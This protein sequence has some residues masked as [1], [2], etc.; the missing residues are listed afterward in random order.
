MTAEIISWLI[1]TKVWDRA[2]IELTTPGSSVAIDC[3][4]RPGILWVR[5]HVLMLVNYKI[6]MKHS[7]VDYV[8]Y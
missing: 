4:T 5:L 2:R 7:F 8:K 6:T 1:S 3:A